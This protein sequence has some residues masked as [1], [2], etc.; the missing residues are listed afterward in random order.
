MYR[1]IHPYN[2]V[3]DPLRTPS[4]T[5]E[6]RCG[7]EMSESAE[8]GIGGLLGAESCGG[9]GSSVVF[10]AWIL[11]PRRARNLWNEEGLNRWM[12]APG[13]GPARES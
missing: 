4:L 6:L 2:T 3:Q 10:E 9:V 13:G 8:C 7:V 1:Y 11:G 12:K 5:K